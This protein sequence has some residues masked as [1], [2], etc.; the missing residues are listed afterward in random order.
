MH[1]QHFGANVSYILLFP[2]MILVGV[3]FWNVGV[4]E[5]YS[6]SGLCSGFSFEILDFDFWN[7]IVLWLWKQRKLQWSVT[8]RRSEMETKK[9]E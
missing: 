7:L 4:E 1:G 3:C 9:T 8:K 6:C 2:E 5:T